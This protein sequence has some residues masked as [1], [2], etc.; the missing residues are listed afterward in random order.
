MDHGSVQVCETLNAWAASRRVAGRERQPRP[1]G[2]LFRSVHRR[3]SDCEFR[4]ARPPPASTPIAHAERGFCP[5]PKFRRKG[6]SSQLLSTNFDVPFFPNTASRIRV[7][8]PVV[9]LVRRL[10][11]QS[12]V[13]SFLVIEQEITHQPLV[14]LRAVKQAVR[15]LQGKGFLELVYRGRLNGGPSVYRVHPTG[16][17][18]AM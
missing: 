2:A 15:S 13:R 7:R 1:V 5:L 6:R 4:S 18:A 16:S 10:V 12:L 17:H 9:Q 11:V 14:S 3:E 8:P